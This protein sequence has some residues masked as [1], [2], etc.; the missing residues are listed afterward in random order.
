MDDYFKEELASD[1]EPNNPFEP[2]EKEKRKI[3]PKQEKPKK[4][5]DDK[6]KRKKGGIRL[7]RIL[8]L[9]VIAVVA[10]LIIWLGVFIA[11]R[12]SNGLK[13]AASLAEGIGS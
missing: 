7:K 13:Q 6:G 3:L 5:S 9:A 2:D 4:I 1:K 11:N 8:I 12:N 10:I